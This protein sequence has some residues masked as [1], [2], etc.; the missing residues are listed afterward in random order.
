MH[1][2]LRALLRLEV[3][4]QIAHYRDNLGRMTV[5]YIPP[6][7]GHWT[8][9]YLS[10]VRK[11]TNDIVFVD[12]GNIHRQQLQYCRQ[13][14]HRELARREL[15]LPVRLRTRKA[16]RLLIEPRLCRGP[17]G[18]SDAK[19]DAHLQQIVVG[20]IPFDLGKIAQTE[21]EENLLLFENHL[22]HT[23]GQRAD[24]RFIHRKRL[25]ILFK[26]LRYHTELALHL[27]VDAPHDL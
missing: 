8:R 18:N 5:H 4:N 11:E 24:A 26:R 16:L 14:L 6:E 27:I 12:E 15:Q 21:R 22:T 23:L 25:C 9:E 10:L 2:H 20:A 1:D 19:R 7:C 13:L 17:C 3:R